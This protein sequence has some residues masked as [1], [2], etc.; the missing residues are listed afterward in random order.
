[1]RDD[2][3]RDEVLGESADV[4]PIFVPS[5]LLLKL[6]PEL[7]AQGR[8]DVSPV[9]A[10][11]GTGHASGQ[12]VEL[13]P[14]IAEAEIKQLPLLRSSLALLLGGPHLMLG[15][16]DHAGDEGLQVAQGR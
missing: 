4:V 1:M 3:G 9:E 7:F 16:P 8:L 13:A 2:P 6:V 5:E 14:E 10:A 11:P 12:P 15:S